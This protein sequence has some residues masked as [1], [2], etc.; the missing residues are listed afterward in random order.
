M[1]SDR[2]DSGGESAPR[3]KRQRKKTPAKLLSPE[4]LATRR[5]Q[6]IESAKRS[7][8]RKAQSYMMLQQEVVSLQST[9]AALTAENDALRAQNARLMETSQDLASKVSSLIEENERLRR[10]E[11][12]HMATGGSSTVT[13][14]PDPFAVR[15]AYPNQGQQ[16]QQQQQ[17]A[18]VAQQ[19]Q[20]Q[21]QQAQSLQQ[22]SHHNHPSP[23]SAQLPSPWQ[24]SAPSNTVSP[25]PPRRQM[26]VKR[27]HSQSQSL[28]HIHHP[29]APP[30]QP[31]PQPPQQTMASPP[32]STLADPQAALQTLLI[33]AQQ[34]QSTLAAAAQAAAAA[35][36]YGQSPMNNAGVV[37]ASRSQ[38]QDP[39]LDALARLLQSAQANQQQPQPPLNHHGAAHHNHHHSQQLSP[40]QLGLAPS[41][42]ALSAMTPDSSDSSSARRVATQALLDRVAEAMLMTDPNA[43]AELLG[44]V[45]LGGLVNLG[46]GVKM[47]D[48]ALAEQRGM[49]AAGGMA[50]G[51]EHGYS[52]YGD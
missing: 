5:A 34:L 20:Q 27:S 15:V 39:Q 51:Y 10:L 29:S 4:A 17:Q 52:Y 24:T 28:S 23:S 25:P 48:V 38:E 26:S 32:P 31:Q 50:T 6:N 2:G 13:G 44:S 45:G 11:S 33:Q 1:L 3:K 16:A 37:A 14:S 35:S 9:T 43:A 42:S 12:D 19:Q 7:R 18:Q 47:E 21:Q 40:A 41:P 30:Q 49:V 36:G 8:E 22:L 46:D